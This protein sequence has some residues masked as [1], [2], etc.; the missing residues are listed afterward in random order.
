M[1]ETRHSGSNSVALG[2][3]APNSAGIQMCDRGFASRFDFYR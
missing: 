2:N 1:G 3:V